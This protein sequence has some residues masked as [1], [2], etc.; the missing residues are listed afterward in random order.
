MTKPEIAW[1]L[2]VVF[3]SVTDPSI[4][5]AIESILKA[6]DELVTNYQGKIINFSSKELLNLL[7]E[8]EKYLVE[9]RNL[10]MFSRLTFSANMTI[11]ASQKLFDRVNKLQA[12]LS[13]KLAF[14]T[15]EIGKLVHSKPG[16]ITDKNLA[17][18]KHYLERLKRAVPHQLSEIEEQ[19]IIEKDQFGLRGWSQLQSKW[20]NTRFFEVEVEGEKKKLSYGE[21]NSL[22][23]HP[24]RATRKSANQAIYE[25]L[26]ED[27]ELFTSALRN[28]TNDWISVTKRRQYDSEMHASLIANDID[29]KTIDSLLKTIDKSSPIYRRYLQLK[30]KLLGLPKLASYD[31]VAP[32][33]DAPDISYDYEKAKE[34]SIAAYG[35]FD[36][37]YAFA[38]RDMFEKNRVDASARFG[39]R[40]GA[41]C[42]SWFKGQSA[43]I[44]QSFNDSLSGV[45]TLAHELG[46][47]THDYY[48][49]R[50]QTILNSSIPMIVAETA[51]IF[52]ELLIT[53]LLLSQAQSDKEKIAIISRVLDGAGMAAFQVTA[54]AWFEQDMYD[55]IKRG[56]F[57]DYQTIS[58]FWI[59]N[60]DR[61]YGD[62]IEWQDVMDAE[63]TMKVH[64]YMAN[65]RFYNYPYVYGQL[66]VYALYQKYLEEG[67]DFIPKFKKVLSAGSSISPKEIG[68]IFGLDI[69]DPEFWK[70]G[71]KRYKYFV[72]ELEKLVK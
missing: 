25:L 72:D 59:K 13:K 62:V 34:L 50:E 3:P 38:T 37:E 41:F 39:K 19:L 2:S 69:S 18:Y 67:K 46:H 16:L 58:N 66:F 56:E 65:F 40:N 68:D 53:D 64:Y 49:T 51:S 15:L 28:I 43:F 54:R 26:K 42:A 32:L 27:G 36:D 29:Q 33:P 47:A 8:Y 5:K 55:A 63:W 12:N 14:M 10:G 45:Y 71:I 70:L 6:A 21:A 20:L 7:Q 61:I 4:E 22:L 11:P 23:P 31:I 48:F 24:D 35:K 30:A 1:D 17:K 9:T 52:G 60:R 57:L 44:L